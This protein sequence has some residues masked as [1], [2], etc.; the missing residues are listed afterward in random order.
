MVVML[1]P[2]DSLR[3]SRDPYNYTNS[4]I[5]SLGGFIDPEQSGRSG[6]DDGIDLPVCSPAE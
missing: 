6:D 3:S 4:F 5:S 1:N 2:Q